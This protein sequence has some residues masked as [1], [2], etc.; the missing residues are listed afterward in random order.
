MPLL[1]EKTFFES[2]LLARCGMLVPS[3]HNETEHHFHLLLYVFHFRGF[4]P[5]VKFWRPVAP[6]NE[7]FFLHSPSFPATKY[8][9]YFVDTSGILFY[10]LEFRF[11][12]CALHVFVE[13]IFQRVDVETPSYVS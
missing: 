5:R 1:R 11:V 9:L 4:D 12:K 8:L 10:Q 13:E 2:L 7:K 6:P 3:E